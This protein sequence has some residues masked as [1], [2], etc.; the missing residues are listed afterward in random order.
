M[1]RRTPGTRRSCSHGKASG[2]PLTTFAT[3]VI[4]CAIEVAADGLQVSSLTSDVAARA[5][6]FDL[7]R[8]VRT[9]SVPAFSVRSPAFP[10]SSPVFVDAGLDRGN[11]ARDVA[12]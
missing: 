5:P 3:K 8:P 1:N 7:F 9:A 6:F 2:V 4:A 10:V 12:F 11:R